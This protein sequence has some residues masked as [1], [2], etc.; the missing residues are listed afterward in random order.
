MLHLQE[1]IDEQN[2]YAQFKM[3]KRQADD[4]YRS[5]SNPCNSMRTNKTR[6]R[7]KNETQNKF[8]ACWYC[9]QFGKLPPWHNVFMRT[10]YSRGNVKNMRICVHNCKTILNRQYERKTFL[11]TFSRETNTFF[12]FGFDFFYF[13]SVVI[14]VHFFPI[15]CT[16]S[17][18]AVRSIQS[19][20]FNLVL[21]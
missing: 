6:K 2:R 10:V 16:K 9:L 3:Y 1:Q 17:V 11:C 19:L 20:L 15:D 12:L 18:L 14:L 4:R 8:I 7:E 5:T 13:S 21:E